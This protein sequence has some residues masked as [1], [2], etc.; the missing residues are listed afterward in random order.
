MYSSVP[1]VLH[2]DHAAKKWL[3]CVGGMI[4]AGEQFFKEKSRPLFSS[5]MLDLSEETIEETISM[6]LRFFKRLAPMDMGIE[7]SLA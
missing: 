5:H 7:L 2:T 4:D 6:S 1:V 3:P